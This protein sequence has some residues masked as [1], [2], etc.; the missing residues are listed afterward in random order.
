MQIL[1]FINTTRQIYKNM[2]VE[3][4]GDGEEE[5]VERVSVYDSIN[6]EGLQGLLKQYRHFLAPRK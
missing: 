2:R 4:E 6:T 5:R 1:N 3:K